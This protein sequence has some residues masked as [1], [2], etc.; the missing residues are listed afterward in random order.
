[1]ARLRGT[2]GM[3]GRLLESVR[4]V[5]SAEGTKSKDS[6]RFAG[7]IEALIV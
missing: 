3:N 5:R 7:E 4:F 1:L 6:R 2:F